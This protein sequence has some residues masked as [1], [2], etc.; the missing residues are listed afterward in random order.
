MLK[1]ARFEDLVLGSAGDIQDALGTDQKFSK[2][3]KLPGYCLQP[4][5][6]HPPLRLGPLALSPR[7][8]SLTNFSLDRPHPVPLKVHVM[9]SEFDKDIARRLLKLLSEDQNLSQ[10]RMAAK[11]GVSLGKINYCLA[12]LAEKGFIKIKRFH[13]SA[14]KKQYAYVVT[15]KG[16]AKKAELTFRFLTIK[17]AEYDEIKRQIKELSFEVDREDLRRIL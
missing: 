6:L 7:P 16:M 14:K 10:R 12:R 8:L 2:S 17:L 15:P 5:S 11:M 13:N 9:N 4:R 1:T 3:A